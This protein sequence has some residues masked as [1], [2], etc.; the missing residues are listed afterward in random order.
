M[1]RAILVF[2]AAVLLWLAMAA[3]LAAFTDNGDGTV[4]DPATG[5]M[6]DRCAWGQ[7]LNGDNCDGSASGLNWQAALGIAVEA[8]DNN[9]RSYNDWR[10]PNRTELESLVD[11]T[12]SNPAIDSDAFPSTPS[13][14]F[15][16]STVVTPT[17][18]GAWVVH[19][20]NGTTDAGGQAS[21]SRVRLVRSGQSF[22][23][24]VPTPP[25]NVSATAGNA[26]ATVSWTAPTDTGGSP[27]TGYT[28]TGD[29][30]GS[31]TVAAEV[32]EC[33][34]TGLS[35]G[36]EYSFTVVATNAEGNSASSAPSNAV[37]PAT[38]PDAPT[39]VSATAGNAQATVS[40]TAPTDT[41]G[42][43]ITGYTVTGDPDGSCSVAAEVTECTITGL[44]NGTEYT[45]T[46]VATNAEGTSA[47]S[48]PSASVTPVGPPGGSL[49]VQVEPTMLG[50]IVSWIAPSDN[51]GT[52]IQSYR[53]DANPS[54]EV[55]ALAN[56][57]PGQTAYSCTISNLAPGQEYIVSVTAINAVGES[58]V[59]AGAGATPLPAPIPVPTLGAWAL[60]MLML[61]MFGLA[62]PALLRRGGF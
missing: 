27:I 41:G 24:L 13:D 42:S 52:P 62:L 30:D 15:W 35:N 32:T 14:F 26:Q 16:S 2:S 21:V 55:T 43:P 45:F 33:T 1:N 61:L 9:H 10:L 46:V 17:P 4:T 40:W 60:L 54:C 39:N 22:D 20:L 23:A 53:A 36:T 49:Q 50:L 44:S 3:P 34:I 57:V 59:V 47:S 25:T 37:T 38:V 5:L 51:G 18:G 6:W 29:P 19:F 56:E 48:A 28:V 7:T 11:I 58:T 31:C 8:N 12:Q